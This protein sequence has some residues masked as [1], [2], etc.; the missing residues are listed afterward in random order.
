MRSKSQEETLKQRIIAVCERHG[1]PGL[2]DESGSFQE[3]VAEQHA[4]RIVGAV[5]VRRD[6]E[7]LTPEDVSGLLGGVSK[8]RKSPV[9]KR[10]GKEWDRVIKSRPGGEEAL[11]KQIFNLTSRIGGVHRGLIPSSTEDFR[12][13]MTFPGMVVKTNGILRGDNAVRWQFHS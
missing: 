1:L 3:K 12:F 9:G 6:G 10:F 5:V 11:T 4:R 8:G 2:L 13:T 7:K